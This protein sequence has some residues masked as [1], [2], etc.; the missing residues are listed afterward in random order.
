MNELMN[1]FYGIG[2]VFNINWL[3]ILINKRD[4]Y[5][6]DPSIS[7]ICQFITLFV[8]FY[9]IFSAKMAGKGNIFTKMSMVSS[10]L[11]GLISAFLLGFSLSIFYY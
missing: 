7:F 11:Y 10:N 8:V 4:V 6:L 1:L 3:D 9:F 2:N 5:L